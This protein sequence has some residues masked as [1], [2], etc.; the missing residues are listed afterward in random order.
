MKTQFNID[1]AVHGGK[2]TLT[3]DLKGLEALSANTTRD[4]SAYFAEAHAILSGP[5]AG[6]VEDDAQPPLPGL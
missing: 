1:I 2:V 3:T 4:Y 6:E 5:V